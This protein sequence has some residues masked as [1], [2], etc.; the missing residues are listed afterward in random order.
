MPARPRQSR[1]DRKRGLGGA[2]RYRILEHPADIGFVVYG[3]S[4]PK[5]FENAAQTLAELSFD[6]S[7]VEEKESRA[8]RVQGSDPVALLYNWLSELHSYAEA[9]RFVFKRIEVTGLRENQVYGLGHGELLD[10]SRHRPHTHIK[11]VTYH[12][13]AVKQTPDGWE[14]TVYLDV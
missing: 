9:E 14:A 3:E 4:L 12:Q 6:L 5:L 1:A 10:K 13:F 8:F 11:A 2:P 7:T